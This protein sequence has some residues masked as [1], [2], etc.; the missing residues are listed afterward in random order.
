MTR[1]LLLSVQSIFKNLNK[2][3]GKV[4]HL[5][6]QSLD[7]FNE[8]R[9]S[10]IELWGYSQEQCKEVTHTSEGKL[11]EQRRSMRR[12]GRANS[13]PKE[14]SRHL[15]TTPAAPAMVAS[16]HLLN[17]RNHP[18]LTKEGSSPAPALQGGERA[19]YRLTGWAVSAVNFR[20]APRS[21]GL[22]AATR[23]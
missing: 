13:P 17:G 4:L 23:R 14:A 10:F 21:S 16:R 5:S 3:R 15:Q 8:P 7:A 1:L 19:H 18:S 22:S 6:E 9:E 11:T 20:W 2:I 12:L